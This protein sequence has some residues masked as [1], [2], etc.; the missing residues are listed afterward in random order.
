MKERP[1]LFS[2]PMVQAILSDEKTQTRRLAKDVPPKPAANRHENHKQKHPEPYLDSYC[3]ANRFKNKLN[4]RGM[5]ENW[6][7]WQID[8]RQCLPMFKVPFVPG[9]KAW[10]RE[11]WSHTGTGV[12]RVGDA[13][14]ARD[15]KLVYRADGDIPGAGWFP[16]I[17][18]P[19]AFSRITLEITDIRVQKLQDISEEDA[20]AEGAPFEDCWPT[21]RQSFEALWD[22][23]NG[24][25][26]WGGSMGL[27]PCLQA[28][29]TVRPRRF[30]T[31]R[32]SIWF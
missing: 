3:S 21:Y 4:P 22:N 16:S 8:D 18:M 11:A 5:S 27:C 19:R 2:A 30:V 20:R 9:D 6:C 12:W 32:S 1:I 23:I 15:G 26:A 13:Y 17:H 29:R 24:A 28:C 25:G 14:M 10:V 31:L 7:W